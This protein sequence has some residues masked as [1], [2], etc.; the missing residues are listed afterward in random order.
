MKTE[1]GTQAFRRRL[2]RAYVL[3]TLGLVGFILFLALLEHWGMGR[4]L[5]GLTMLLATVVL[6]AAIGLRCRTSDA[7]EYYVAGRSVPISVAGVRWLNGSKRT[8]RQF[9]HSSSPARFRM[10]S[11]MP[12]P[13]D[14]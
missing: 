7:S 6:Y 11:T 4:N 2:D 10:K 9:S 5:I 14:A 1:P 13:G 3:F 8:E 12:M